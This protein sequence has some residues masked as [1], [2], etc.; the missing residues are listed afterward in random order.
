MLLVV[1]AM[2]KALAQCWLLAL[3]WPRQYVRCPSS[4]IGVFAYGDSLVR[5]FFF[6][7]ACCMVVW[8]SL[9]FLF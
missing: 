6:T 4:G 5:F 2:C 7:K 8:N 3:Y 1:G 9:W